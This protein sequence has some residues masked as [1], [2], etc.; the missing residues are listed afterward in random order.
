MSAERAGK[1]EAPQPHRIAVLLV[2][3]VLLDEDGLGP[4]N[5]GPDAPAEGRS[6]RGRMAQAAF[7]ERTR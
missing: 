4:P 6:T 1:D 2:L 5:P 3:R 7:R